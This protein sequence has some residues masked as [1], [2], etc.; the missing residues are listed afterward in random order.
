MRHS[1]P[2]KL[3]EPELFTV[4]VTGT[5]R[6]P[7]KSPSLGCNSGLLSVG[8]GMFFQWISCAAIWVVGLVGDTLLHSSKAHP[9]AMLG[10]VIWAT[11]KCVCVLVIVCGQQWSLDSYLPLSGNITS[12]PVVKCIGLGLGMLLWGASGLL[13]GW[14]SSR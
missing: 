4:M 10:G 1:V 8:A 6:P 9:A 13:I 5:R 2:E 7:L 12:V 14:A 11:G 3:A